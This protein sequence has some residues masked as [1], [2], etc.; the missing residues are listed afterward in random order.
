[1]D[2]RAALKVAAAGE[3]DIVIARGFAAPRELVFAAYTRAELLKQWLLGPPGWTM[4]IV[5]VDLKVGGQYR[6]AWRHDRDGMEMEVSGVYREIAAPARLVATESFTP[7]W[8][9]GEALATLEF[10]EQGGGTLLTQ[11]MTYA[12]RKARDMAIAT[13]MEDGMAASYDRLDGLLLKQ[14]RR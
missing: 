7:A 13:P 4:F 8:Y 9:E 12:S 2:R 3:R 11:T 14:T 10:K 1:M 6:Y 5:A